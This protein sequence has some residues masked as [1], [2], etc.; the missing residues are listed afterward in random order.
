MNPAFNLFP[1]TA[2]QVMEEGKPVSPAGQELSTGRSA[3]LPGVAGA[4][5]PACQRL[6]PPAGVST[7]HARPGM[8]GNWS[9][10]GI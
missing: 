10:C 4:P 5:I 6:H 7:A 3:A 2:F 8:F 1:Q 9:V